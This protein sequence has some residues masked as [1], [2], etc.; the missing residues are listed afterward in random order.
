MSYAA[1]TYG[2][3]P[4][5]QL[6]L[7]QLLAYTL[8][9]KDYCKEINKYCESRGITLLKPC[10]YDE[11]K[12]IYVVYVQRSLEWTLLKYLV[13]EIE[14]ILNPHGTLITHVKASHM[15]LCITVQVEPF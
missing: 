8:S 13:T 4:E 12:C 9:P 3:Q 2:Y 10:I 15:G 11:E 1:P 6:Q 14:L 5:V 7:F